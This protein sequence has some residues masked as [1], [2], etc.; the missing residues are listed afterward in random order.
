VVGGE[1]V[2]TWTEKP[3]NEGSIAVEPSKTEVN[4]IKKM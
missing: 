4:V 3:D 1:N 2:H